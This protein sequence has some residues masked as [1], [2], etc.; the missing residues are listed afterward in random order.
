MDT[1]IVIPRLDVN[2]PDIIVAVRRGEAP[3]TAAGF[4]GIKDTDS[5]TFFY[6]CDLAVYFFFHVGVMIGKIGNIMI[7]KRQIMT[8]H[9]LKGIDSL[10]T[11]DVIKEI[12]LSLNIQFEEKDMKVQTYGE[13]RNLIHVKMGDNVV[14]DCTTQQAFYK[15][16]QAISKVMDVDRRS[17]SPDSCMDELFPRAGRKKMI[18]QLKSTLGVS[19]TFLE[20]KGWIS[21]SLLL[22]L[23]TSFVALFFQWR[24][25]LAGLGISCLGFRLADYLGK[26]F[27]MVTVGDAAKEM[28]RSHYMKSR[29]NPRTYNNQEVDA[30]I[31]DCFCDRLG[32]D[33][34][35]LT[36]DARF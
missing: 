29:R 12:E 31:R 35:V 4:A 1:E 19:M 22:F 6:C 2:E 36:P 30:L 27:S 33:P 18:R 23:L 9:L 15:L 26:E 24:Y 20:P 5:I 16:R 34:E 17:F 11:C 21:G 3:G 28:A 10:D 14:E 32:L 13:F 25:G 8:E 7:D